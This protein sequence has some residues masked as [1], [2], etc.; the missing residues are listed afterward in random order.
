MPN[1]K[2]MYKNVSNYM[3]VR[4]KLY[5][6]VRGKSYCVIYRSPKGRVNY[7]N[8]ESIRF[9]YFTRIFELARRTWDNL[10]TIFWA[11]RN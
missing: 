10:K 5:C 3:S 9:K 11:K 6:A 7:T 8:F 1:L 4:G 2:A